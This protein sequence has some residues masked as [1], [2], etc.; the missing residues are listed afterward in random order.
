MIIS[1]T[2][3]IDNGAA[4]TSYTILIRQS[5]GITFTA[6]TASCDGSD[7]TIV[8]QT[9]C[10]VPLTTLTAAPYSLNFGDSIYAKVI[11]TNVKGDS[12]ESDEGNGAIIIQVP[13]API[14]LAEDT[15]LRTV[16]T[17]GLTWNSGASDGGSTILDYRISFAE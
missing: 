5:D 10:T 17:I 12:I 14:N 13:D 3:P 11:A 7:S 6:D 8:S 9:Q 4:I 16:T 2:A 1:W 15:S